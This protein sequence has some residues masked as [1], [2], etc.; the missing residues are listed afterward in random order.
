MAH[1][2]QVQFC[3][4]VRQQ[5]PEYFK[6][7][8]VLDVG[9]LDI[10]GNNRYLFEDCSYLGIDIGEGKNVDRVCIAH[11]FDEP[12]SSYELI[13]S[14]ECFEHDMHYDKTIKNIVRLLGSGGMFI[15]T[16]ATE[17]REEHGTRRSKPQ[18]AP[19]LNNYDTWGDYYKNLTEQDIRNVIDVDGIF[20]KYQFEVNEISHDLYFFGIKK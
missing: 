13:I 1:V 18:D 3:S 17:G 20:E 16:C 10:N 15:F 6:N 4:K 7:K 14:A 11:E 8:K 12:D 19:F 2:E 9:S 5:F